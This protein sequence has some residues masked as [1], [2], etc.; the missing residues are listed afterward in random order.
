MICPSQADYEASKR[1]KQEKLARKAAVLARQ[2]PAG[3]TQVPA[4]EWHLR[5]YRECG[6]KTLPAKGSHGSH[7]WVVAWAHRL[8]MLFEPRY[9]SEAIALYA[10]AC[11]W[12]TRD[13]SLAPA[14]EAAWRLGK[15]PAVRGLLQELASR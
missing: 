8:L 10:R 13:Q 11:E 6:I 1:R 2:A 9:L 14:F 12:C 7:V 5:R 4:T 15:A 3:W